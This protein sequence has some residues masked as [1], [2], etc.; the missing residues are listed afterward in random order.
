M[1]IAALGA[2]MLAGVGPVDCLIRGFIAY[3]VGKLATSFWYI[4]FTI[5]VEKAE[6]DPM[7]KEQEDKAPQQAAA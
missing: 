6:P 5:R 3:W 2:S 4:F 7:E 1:A